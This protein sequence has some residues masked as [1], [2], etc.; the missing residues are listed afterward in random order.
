MP[1]EA[2]EIVFQARAGQGAK[3]AAH[4]LAEAAI[5]EGKHVKAF[6]EYGPERAGAPMKSYVRL[7]DKPVKTY[8]AIEEPDVLAV[9][10]QSLLSPEITSGLK[11]DGLLL[12]NT[13]G[14]KDSVK[15]KTGYNG[16]IATVDATGIAI[17]T[18]NDDLPNT[19]ML[20]ALVRVTEILEM[21]TIT[22]RVKKFFLEKQK[23]EQSQANVNAL[24]RGYAEVKE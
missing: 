12:V 10:D 9:I 24:K 21:K 19:A 15:E 17:D 2:A 14:T 20:G 7:S 16:K 6:P 22:N 4:L 11:K 18:L 5:E 3:S 8:A 23:H 1:Q 13:T